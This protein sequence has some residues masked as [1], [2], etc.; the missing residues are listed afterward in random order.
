[1]TIYG[2]YCARLS[3]SWLVQ[4][5]TGRLT[6]PEYQPTCFR[7]PCPRVDEPSA[8]RDESPVIDQ[9]C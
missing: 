4:H 9:N 5:H 1:M 6:K 3:A 2:N 8:A 7:R